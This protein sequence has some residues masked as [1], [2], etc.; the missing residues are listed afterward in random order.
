MHSGGV[1]RHSS[2]S[3]QRE[4]MPLREPVSWPWTPSVSLRHRW[5]AAT[6][7]GMQRDSS[8]VSC[9]KCHVWRYGALIPVALT[10]RTWIWRTGMGL[11]K[12][13]GHRVIMQAAVV[14][15]M[16]SLFESTGHASSCGQSG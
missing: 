7:A 9:L 13:G 3:R 11:L 12:R 4:M 8:T 16:Q 15:H 1:K 5:C 14:M 6:I 10:L 2:G